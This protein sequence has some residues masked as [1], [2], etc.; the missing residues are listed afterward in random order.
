MRALGLHRP[1]RGVRTREPC[2][3]VVDAARAYATMLRDGQAFTG[4]TA[5]R[6]WG[7]PAPGS[8]HV[9]E[10]IA[11]ATPNGATREFG[12]DAVGHEYD[13][14]RFD[15]GRAHDLPVLSPAATVLVLARTL[16][17]DDLVVLMDALLTPS[18]RYPGLALPRRPHA[19]AAGLDAFA[20]R[21]K[22]TPGVRAFRRAIADARAGS[23]SPQETRTRLLIV[24]DG[25]PEPVVQHEVRVEGVLV[26][27][28]D[29]AYPELKIDIE[30]EGEHHLVDPEQ[31]QH[32]IARHEALQRLGWIVIRLTHDLRDGG[33]RALARIREALATRQGIHPRGSAV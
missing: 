2:D 3:S 18:R 25:I 11:V 30:Y 7:L 14:L 15:V 10:P 22:G 33:R 28:L 31:W 6:L 26:A 4:I 8:W 16:V 1:Y 24:R 23:D 21:C 20:T 5:A 12:A 13:T 27:V 29:L 19:S 17:H 32:D 9:D